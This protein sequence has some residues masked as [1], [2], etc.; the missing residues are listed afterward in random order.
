MSVRDQGLYIAS[1]ET[2]AGNTEHFSVTLTLLSKLRW[3]SDTNI[4]SY[5]LRQLL[6]LI[7]QLSQWAQ[8]FPFPF[9]R[10][11]QDSDLMRQLK[12]DI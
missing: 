5:K 1:L 7:G 4:C 8:T 10:H 12:K 3:I 9:T 6:N 11:E 2:S